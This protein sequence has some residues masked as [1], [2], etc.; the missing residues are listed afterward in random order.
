[1]K[2]QFG[3]KVAFVTGAARGQGRSHAVRFAEEGAE[4]LDLDE[5]V[6]LVEKTG[7]R[8]VAD[9]ADVRD[10][11]RLQSVVSNAV[12]GNA[13]R[14]HSAHGELTP[15]EFALQGTTTHQPQAAQRLDH[16]TGQAID[17]MRYHAITN[18][19][20]RRDFEL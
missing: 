10:F 7:R 17:E 20:P 16:Q 19:I 18:R 3:D 5:T 8:I 1:M 6:S 13:N 14:P 9:Q 2:L 4:P 12:T 15:T 11:S